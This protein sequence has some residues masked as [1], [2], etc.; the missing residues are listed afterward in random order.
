MR[1]AATSNVNLGPYHISET[2]KFYT[3][4]DMFNHTF[5]VRFQLSISTSFRDMMGSKYRVGDPVPLKRP[6]A[7]TNSHPKSVLDPS[8]CA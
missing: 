1:G 3:H 6:L 7:E 4:L 5:R 2:I 8:K